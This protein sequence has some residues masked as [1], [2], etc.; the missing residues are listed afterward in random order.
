MCGGV[1]VPVSYDQPLTRTKEIFNSSEAKCIISDIS[2]DK[3]D[4]LSEYIIDI[5][6]DSK[7]KI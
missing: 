4:D 2:Y 3:F 7:K 1:Y 6:C 5:Y